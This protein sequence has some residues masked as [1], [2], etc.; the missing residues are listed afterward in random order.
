MSKVKLLGKN[1]HL[2]I[3]SG[4]ETGYNWYIHELE[5]V[6]QLLSS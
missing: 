1:Q 3:I 6:S 2:K 4:Q 5:V